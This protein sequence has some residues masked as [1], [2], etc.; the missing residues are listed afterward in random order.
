MKKTFS[1]WFICWPVCDVFGDLA[2]IAATQN[3]E[4]I[5]L[6]FNLDDL[7]SSSD[8]AGVLQ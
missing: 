4:L 3:S 6:A 8:Q 7:D 2:L 1:L 5:K